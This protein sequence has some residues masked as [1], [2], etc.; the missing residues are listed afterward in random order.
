MTYS[1]DLSAPLVM[2]DF[3]TT[4]MGPEM[5]G[6]ITEV[7]A[8]RIEGRQITQRFVSLVN[9]GAY[10]SPFITQL[11]GITQKMVDGAPPAAEIVP[12][13][14]EFIGSDVLAAHNA[15][16]DQKFLLNEARLQGIQ[17]RH[18]GMLCS[19]MLARRL[20]PGYRSYSLGQIAAARG[21]AFSSRAHRAE[22]DA[23][24]AAHLVLQMVDK[25]GRDFGHASI[26]PQLLLQINQKSAAQTPAFL[27]KQLFEQA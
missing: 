19:V 7:A 25:L 18:A 2:L 24:V 12:A 23:E 14:L 8:L 22:A 3:E 15:S 11:T 27:R 21:I 10:V 26:A 13:L 20:L 6:R 4:D 16:F 17:P 1:T 5:G 9:C